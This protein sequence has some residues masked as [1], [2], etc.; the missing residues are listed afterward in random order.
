MRL[1]RWTGRRRRTLHRRL[2]TSAQQRR[3]EPRVTPLPLNGTGTQRPKH[4]RRQTATAATPTKAA[5]GSEISAMLA[6]HRASLG[7]LAHAGG[8][9]LAGRGNWPSLR[10][11]QPI[12][13]TA[14]REA[15]ARLMASRRAVVR[16]SDGT[17]GRGASLILRRGPDLR[18]GPDRQ[19]PRAAPSAALPAGPGLASVVR[20][21]S[22]A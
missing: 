20:V 16:F 14:V 17:A 1:K 19:D 8:G 4:A 3:Q 11:R 13:W 9:T 2:H 15:A 12:P 21:V 7:G 6:V 18:G 10:R 22:A 5:S